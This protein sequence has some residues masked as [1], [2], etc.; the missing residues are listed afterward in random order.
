MHAAAVVDRYRKGGSPAALFFGLAH[1][2]FFLHSGAPASSDSG[3]EHVLFPR[4]CLFFVAAAAAA[5]FFLQ[6]QWLQIFCACGRAHARGVTVGCSDGPAVA[7]L[8]RVRPD[9]KR[10]I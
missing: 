10:V 9:E 7:A 5:L 6:L 1:A 4:R 3:Q 8:F 2:V